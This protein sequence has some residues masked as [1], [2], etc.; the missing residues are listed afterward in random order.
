MPC[1]RGGDRSRNGRMTRVLPLSV[2]IPAV[3][4]VFM[5]AVAVLVSERVLTRLEDVQDCAT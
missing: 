1:R 5:A 2:K 4:F 3:V